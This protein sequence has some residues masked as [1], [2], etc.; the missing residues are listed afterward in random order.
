M[1]WH[2]TMSPDVSCHPSHP[3]L[4]TN[5]RHAQSN[6]R[7]GALSSLMP[8]SFSFWDKSGRKSLV[9]FTLCHVII[10]MIISWLWAP[11]LP[12]CLTCLPLY[13]WHS[14][15]SV[16]AP[17]SLAS[18][19][20]FL[21]SE[22]GQSPPR[23]ADWRWLLVSEVYEWPLC[24]H[25]WYWRRPADI[26]HKYNRKKDIDTGQRETPIKYQTVPCWH[27]LEG[28]SWLASAA[29]VESWVLLLSFVLSNLSP[30][31][32][33]KVSNL[34]KS[35]SSSTSRIIPNDDLWLNLRK[36]SKVKNE[37]TA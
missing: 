37:I 10:E 13:S 5:I 30:S 27:S 28:S 32:S 22:T 34:S 24:L 18:D 2:A 21:A 33:G 1:S 4:H 6:V 16:P 8:L 20:S 3:T 7:F 15:G 36:V 14:V 12:S 23:E 35:V 9:N 19:I 17:P 31:S 11:S 25:V 29:F 26:L